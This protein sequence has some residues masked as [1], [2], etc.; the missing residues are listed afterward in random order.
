MEMH[1]TTEESRKI[2]C[3][4]CGY[5]SCEMMATAVFN[6]FNKKENCIHFVK[7]EVEKEKEKAYQLTKEVE[8]EKDQVLAQTR[9]IQEAV[10]QV[11]EQF[12][13][14]YELMKNMNIGNDTN[15]EESTGISHDMVQVNEFCENLRTSM[16]EIVELLT[17]LEKNNAEVVSIAGQTNLLALNANIEAA[18][19]G[20]AGR[21]FAV[22]A[23]EISK[24]AANSKETAT[25]SSSGQEQMLGSITA[26][27]EETKVLAET[28]GKVNGRVQNL[29]ASTEEISASSSQVIEV[30]EHVKE[31]MEKLTK[32]GK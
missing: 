20:E 22:V 29:A 31:I 30:V 15:A 11:D 14:L 18:R 7:D 4:C 32:N 19:A 1:K 3:E 10:D 2:D 9:Q 26:I 28:V 25:R 8:K 13:A 12:A 27:L 16:D 23:D 6:G 21:G 24:L 5:K 17:T